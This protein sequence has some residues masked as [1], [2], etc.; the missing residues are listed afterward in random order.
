MKV[1]TSKLTTAQLADL[2]KQ[3]LNAQ[4]QRHV[5]Y[6]MRSPEYFR[7][8][9][10]QFITKQSGREPDQIVAGL[11]AEAKRKLEAKS[12]PAGP[13][14]ASMV[15]IID[16][17]K[18]DEATAVNPHTVIA[19]TCSGCNAAIMVTYGFLQSHEFIY[20]PTCQPQAEAAD[21]SA[22]K[23]MQEFI[24]MAP[25]FYPIESNIMAIA[26]EADRCKLTSVT[27]HDLA[28]IYLSLLLEGKL[29]KRL[30]S[31]DIQTMNSQELEARA[32]IDPQLG[33]ADLAKAKE[34]QNRG[35]ELNYSSNKTRL[36][37]FAPDGTSSRD[38]SML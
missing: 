9:L 13:P 38:R 3:V 20:C 34:G 7:N 12:K 22:M 5:A 18:Q 35:E 2:A 24:K 1:I 32:K 14:Q 8:D 19:A 30:T 6:L 27:A 10:I 33:G 17:S 31:A 36:M 15:R 23:A 26:H 29:L 25:D 28:G 11:A 16:L 4:D 37:P 21:K